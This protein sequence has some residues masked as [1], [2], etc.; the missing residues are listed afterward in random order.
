MEIKKFVQF[1][2]KSMV[3]FVLFYITRTAILIEG[4]DHKIAML[5]VDLKLGIFHHSFMGDELA[6]IYYK[7]FRIFA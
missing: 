6:L 2:H 7:L 4:R 5:V 3:K 1:E